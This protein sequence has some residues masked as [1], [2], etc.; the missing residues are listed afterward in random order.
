MQKISEI[1]KW[2]QI[3]HLCSILIPKFPWVLTISSPA[4]CQLYIDIYFNK[5][6]SLENWEQ[7]CAK[8]NPH[9]LCKCRVEL[10][11]ISR[12]P[13]QIVDKT[14]FQLSSSVKLFTYAYWPFYRKVCFWVNRNL[15]HLILLKGKRNTSRT[16]TQFNFSTMN[17]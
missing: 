7:Y 15:R 8:I 16:T 1:L 4:N 5:S 6:V 13:C 3:L 12:W 9:F 10:K 11:K 2:S 14:F 17:P